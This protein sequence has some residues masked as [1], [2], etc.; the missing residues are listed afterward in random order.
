MLTT[1]ERFKNALRR[2]VLKPLYLFSGEEKYFKEKIFREIKD[3]LGSNGDFNYEEIDGLEINPEELISRAEMASFWGQRFLIV[4]NCRFFS[5]K[6]EDNDLLNY[7]NNPSPQA[8][9]IFSTEQAVDRKKKIYKEFLKAGEEVEFSSLKEADL[10]VILYSWA[11]KKG[12]RI[13]EEAAYVLIQSF[14]QSLLELKKEFTKLMLY[15]LKEKV[16]TLEDVLEVSGQHK[17]ISVFYLVEELLAGKI[18]RKKLKE[19]LTNSEEAIKFTG[20]IAKN[21]RQIYSIKYLDEKHQVP[22]IIAKSLNVPEWLV[23]KTLRTTKD[24]KL[25][26]LKTMLI[27]LVEVDEK[28]K[29]G[30]RDLAGLFEKYFLAQIK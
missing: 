25:E 4:K 30:E 27:S 19:Q 15:K 29:T 9:V 11:E 26:K 23:K 10:K 14:G 18:N 13:E 5:G 28:I 2:G 7:F 20:L 21:L 12:I 16:I 17:D 6:D 3:Y 8:V 22:G 24:L 1:Y